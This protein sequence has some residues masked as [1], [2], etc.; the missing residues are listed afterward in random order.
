MKQLIQEKID[1]Y[2]GLLRPVKIAIMP[3]NRQHKMDY[4]LQ[5]IYSEIISDLK[6]LLNSIEQ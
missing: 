3:P 1:K 4:L 5:R 6:Q 2:E